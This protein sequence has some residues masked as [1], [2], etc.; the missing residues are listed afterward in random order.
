MICGIQVNFEIHST[1]RQRGKSMQSYSQQG[2]ESYTSSLNQSRAAKG[3]HISI[4]PESVPMVRCTFHVRLIFC[5]VLSVRWPESTNRIR[6]WPGKEGSGVILWGGGKQDVYCDAPLII[7]CV[8]VC[9]WFVI[10]N[11]ADLRFRVVKRTAFDGEKEL[12]IL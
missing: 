2:N 5:T 3:P 4:F 10:A 12:T 9:V 1:A 11:T 7:C 8:C 6:P